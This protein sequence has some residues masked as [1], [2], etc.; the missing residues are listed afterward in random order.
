MRTHFLKALATISFLIAV[1]IVP[2]R[3]AQA[4]T[5]AYRVRANIPFDFIVADKTF[6]AGE[7]YIYRTREYSGD[8]VVT[9]GTT[10]GR[11][12]ALRLTTTV[13]TLTPKK[14]GVVIFHR[15]GNQHFLAQV[16]VAGS[17]TGRS[18]SK[19]R[20]ERELEREVKSIARQDR[21]KAPAMTTVSVVLGQQ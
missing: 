4:Q 16:R 21:E 13:Q 8:D 7:Y 18:F 1:A 14:Q 11:T 2:V 6:P 9:V 3:S 15:Y 20:S 17:N 12:L 19:S 10:D 5:L